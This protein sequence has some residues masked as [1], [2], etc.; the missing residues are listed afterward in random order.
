MSPG[1]RLTRVLLGLGAVFA[2]AL[3]AAL[4]GCGGGS[5]LETRD[6]A[7]TASHYAWQLP[8][9]F[10]RPRVPEDNPL[11]EDKAELGR[12]LFY[13]TRLS[14]NG[15]QA[16]ASCHHQDKAFT[17]GRAVAVGS[18]GENHPR[19]AQGLANVVYHPTLTWANPSLLSLEAQLQVP[20]F[21]DNPVEMG[22]NDS[23]K[24]E[25]R[26]RIRS[27]PRYAS[28][29]ARAYPGATTAIDWPQITQALASFQ[30]TLISANSRYD[31]FL[32]GRETFTA[33][34]Q[35]GLNLF[36]GEKA[37]CFHCHA[38]HNLNDQVVHASTQVLDTPFHNTGL[39]NIGNTGNFPEPNQGLFDFTNK[40]GDRGKF[41]APSL[42]NV[43]VTAPFMHDGSVATLEAVLDHYAAGGRLIT[44]GP[45]AGD[46]RAHP[47]KSD[48]ISRIELNAQERAD[49][50][51]FLKTLTDEEF[52]RNPKFSNPF[53]A[54]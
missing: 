2:T 26:G 4:S 23:N 24:D 52:L 5:G 42:R 54:Q 20:L 27:D 33:A 9:D 30:R 50:V 25:V 8:A 34:E 32:A 3:G 21:G 40:P 7:A 17:D 1:Q 41:R 11:T 44:S 18:T 6:S 47:N 31:R 46:G 51:A 45:Y 43:A 53:A 10:P 19:N 13:D 49:I 15:T 39:Y 16:C 37:E 38:G 36:F 22:V 35:R 29:Y 48:L 28:L 14:G 12:H